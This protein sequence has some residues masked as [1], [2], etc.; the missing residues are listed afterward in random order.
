MKE[1]KAFLPKINFKIST[2]D[3]NRHFQLVDTRK[4]NEIGFDDYTRLYLNLINV[5]T[6]LYE[7]FNCQ[8]PYSENGETVTLKEFESFLEAEQND[9]KAKDDQFISNFIQ[10]FVQDTQ[11]EV[12]EPYFTV[13]EFIDYLFSKQNEIWDGKKCNQIYQVRRF[14]SWMISTSMTYLLFLGYDKASLRLLDFF[15][16]QYISFW[17]SIFQRIFH[18]GICSRLTNGLSL[19]WTWLLGWTR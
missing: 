10:E 16:T 19:H 1:V 14:N 5:P 13:N 4:R 17:R 8:M 18:R 12:Q 2:S 3:L 15:L 9:E 7:C 11:R 6:F